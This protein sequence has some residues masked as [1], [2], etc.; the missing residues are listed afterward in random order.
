M[1]V[2]NK[3]LLWIRDILVRIRI[4]GSVTM[5]NESGCGSERPNN[6][7]MRIR[8]ML[9]SHKE[10]TQNNRNQGFSFLYFCLMMEGSGSVLVTNGSGSGRPRNIWILGIRIHNTDLKYQNYASR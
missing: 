3:A 9:K 5:S 2:Q 6:I 1:S 7:R 8:T 4:L 10:V